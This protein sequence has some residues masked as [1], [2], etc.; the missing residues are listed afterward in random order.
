MKID[1]IIRTKRKTIA[2]IVQRDGSLVVRAPLRTSKSQILELVEKNASWIQTRLEEVKLRYAS[3]PPVEYREG[4]SFYFLGKTV[5]L[6]WVDKASK[7]LE[8]RG[9]TFWLKKAAVSNAQEVFKA[10]YREQAL[11]LLSDRTAVL[12]RQYGFAY[13][14][15]KI[16]SARTR[17]GSCSPTGTLSYP[18]RLVMA[19]LPV[20]DY[21]IIHELVH[22]QIKNHAKG[23]WDKVKT[24]LPDYRQHKEWLKNQGY[25]YH[26]G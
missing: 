19:P 7:P 26:L 20:I 3:I 17:W 13:Q 8:L 2:L 23:F 18:W 14:Q 22:T 16:T 5:Q 1:K 6:K 11:H 21:V 12:A 4:E 10:W 25:L 24:I 15:V 9:E